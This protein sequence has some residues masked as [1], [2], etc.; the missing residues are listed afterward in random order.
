MGMSQ[1]K[2]FDAAISQYR[3]A[4]EK[5]CDDNGHVHFTNPEEVNA[6]LKRIA[7]ILHRK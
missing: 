2:L 4:A 6:A 5:Q 7:S 3:T 1:R